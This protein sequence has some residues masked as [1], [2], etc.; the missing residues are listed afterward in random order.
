MPRFEGITDEMIIEKHRNGFSYKEM[1]EFCGLTDRAIRGILVKHG[2]KLRKQYSGQPRKYKVNEDFFKEWSHEMAWVFGFFV[3]DGYI[4]E[5]NHQLGFTQKYDDILKII[6]SYMDADLNIQYSDNRVPCLIIN[7]K[8][9][10]Q[11]LVKMGVTNNKSFDMPFPYVPKVFLPSFI[12]GIIE[13]DGWVDSKGYG[14]NITTGS[15][16]L[17]DGLKSVFTDWELFSEIKSEISDNNNTIYRVWVK[18]K[19][20]V[21]KLSE[22]IYSTPVDN[23]CFEYKRIRMSQRNEFYIS[24]TISDEMIKVV[25]NNRTVFKTYIN[26]NTLDELKEMAKRENT[27]ISSILENGLESLVNDKYFT[28]NKSDR[29]R[30]KVE[31]RT[32][33]DKEILNRAKEVAKLYKLNFTDIIQ[34]S[35]SYIGL[36]SIV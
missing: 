24:Q 14:V 6:A 35:I 30:D 26:K 20:D 5:E 21:L 2:I 3:A 23:D 18:G 34:A 31:F 16:R 29:I 33:C 10:K 25:D 15:S 22:I 27:H 28:F 19:N 36:K 9:M 7:S 17:A 8:I 1:E 13:G 4:T 11:D 12:R 32:T